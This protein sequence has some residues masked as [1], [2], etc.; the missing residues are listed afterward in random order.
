MSMNTEPKNEKTSDTMTLKPIKA[1]IIYG[2]ST[3]WW[4]A[5][6]V[7]ENGWSAFS[8]LCSDPCFMKGDLWTRR[9]ERQERLRKMGY[10]VELVGEPI[11]GSDKSPEGL[12]EKH[13]DASNWQEMADAYKEL[14]KLEK[15]TG[16]TE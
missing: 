1:Y 9:R 14:E 6:L 12:L 16:A 4:T 5:T 8:H 13:Q 3:Q 10:E 15:A 11:A 2:G 7:F